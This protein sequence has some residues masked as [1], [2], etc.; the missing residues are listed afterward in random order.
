MGPVTIRSFEDKV[1]KIA[2]TAWVS[3]AAYVVGDVEIG[4]DSSIWPGAVVRGDFGSIRIGENT[5]IE[6][7]C[8]VHCAGEM[9]I[10]DHNIIGHA[11][12]VHGAAIGSNCLIGN[13]TILLDDSR[14][15]D[16]CMVAA[17]SLVRA[18]TVVP[19]RSFVVG[20]P[21]RIEP[22]G[23]GRVGALEAFERRDWEYS[24]A[25]LAKRYRAA[26]L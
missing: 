1:P 4:E 16:L 14:I 15:G 11:V 3:E 6:D 26:G 12:T 5:V 9:V 8:I 24:Y 17:G 19:D 25:A 20:S 23:D 13:G 7:T 10:G 22:L 2:P 18:R 21:A